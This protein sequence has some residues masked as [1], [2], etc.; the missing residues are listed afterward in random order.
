MKKKKNYDTNC[1][2]KI[3]V[4]IEGIGPLLMHNIRLV[5]PSNE[6]VIQSR[7]ITSKS[8]GKRTKE[9]DERLAFLGFMGGLYYD[10]E[11]GPYLPGGS[12]QASL[13][14][15][16]RKNKLGGK[17]KS[18]VFAFEDAPLLYDG[19][20]K[21][22]DMW[23][24]ETP[25]FCDTRAVTIGKARVMRTRP[26]FQVGWRC[27]YTLSLSAGA[28]FDVSDIK[29]AL[30]KAGLYSGIGDYRPRFGRYKVNAFDVL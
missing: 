1:V 17:F 16:A 23:E 10:D 12:L 20:R 9:D 25:S 22:E 7:E 14:D 5:D 21:P 8:K 29:T 27:D 18:C 19:P 2:E 3:A 24:S 30:E 15:G 26:I 28:E 4:S 11:L 13:Y 6:Y